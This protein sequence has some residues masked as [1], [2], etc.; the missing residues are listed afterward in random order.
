MFSLIRRLVS[1]F[2]AKSPD[3][4]IV[5]LP[6]EAVAYNFQM[7]WFAGDD[8]IPTEM[9]GSYPP[10]PYQPGKGSSCRMDDGVRESGLTLAWSNSHPFDDGLGDPAI[11]FPSGR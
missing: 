4:E 5:E 11:Y 10:S 1:Q 6:W 2:R 9:L 7:D 3:P 8:N